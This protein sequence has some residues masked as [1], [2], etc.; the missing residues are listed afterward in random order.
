MDWIVDLLLASLHAVL[1]STLRSA[2]DT[3]S[4]EGTSDDVVANTGKV[5]DTTTS[6]EHDR[7]L[8]EVVPLSTDVC[9]DLATVG[10]PNSSNLTERG[11]WFLRGLGLHL[12]ADTSSLGTRVKVTD[13]TLGVG[14]AARLA[15]E[16]INRG[17]SDSENRRLSR[18]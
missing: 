13:L 2:V 9:T 1:G 7:V 4:V 5:S 14:L 10:Q 11:V 15:D 16:L 12:K 3:E 18:K 6:N 17:H 8:L